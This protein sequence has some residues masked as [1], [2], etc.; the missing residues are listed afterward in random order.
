MNQKLLKKWFVVQ[1]KPNSYDLA[2]RNLERQGFETFL[3]K[4][5]ATIK[6]ENKFINKDVLVFPGYAFIGINQ[7][8][9]YWTKINST[10]GVSKLLS[11]NNKPYEIPFDLVVALKNKYDANSNPIINNNLKKGDKIKF[12]NGP[13]ADFVANIESVN[14]KNRVYALLKVMG[15]RRKLEIN[16]EEKINFIKL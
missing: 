4:M 7:Q 3:P 5:K 2:L 16:L 11:F 1:I 12:N 13:F 8:N 9:S 15:G 6:K 10:Y 14:P